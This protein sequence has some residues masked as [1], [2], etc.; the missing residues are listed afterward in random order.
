MPLEA[1]V[2]THTEKFYDSGDKSSISSSSSKMHQCSKQEDVTTFWIKAGSVCQETPDT[3]IPKSV[4]P[5]LQARFSL[6]DPHVGRQMSDD[7]NN[8][9]MEG[10]PT[11]L[12]C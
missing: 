11:L 5:P 9:D 8:N 2:E 10:R 6:R 12:V 4:S 1:G 3:R 7:D